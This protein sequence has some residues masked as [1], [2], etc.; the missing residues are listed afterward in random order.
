MRSFGEKYEAFRALA[1]TQLC[2]LLLASLSQFCSRS[3]ARASS[4][5]KHSENKHAVCVLIRGKS[6]G[7][8]DQ[9][10]SGVFVTL[11]RYRRNVAHDCRQEF[12][13]ARCTLTTSMPC[14]SSHAGRDRDDVDQS[15]S[16]MF[17]TLGLPSLSHVAHGRSQELLANRDNLTTGL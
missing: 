5:R 12:L 13:S 1:C 6:I 10:S 4:R 7:D 15:L 8:D 14:A 17:C 9:L 16:R 3:L 2:T 11:T